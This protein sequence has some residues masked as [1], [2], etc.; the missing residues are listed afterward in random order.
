MNHVNFQVGQSASGGQKPTMLMGATLRPLDT[1]QNLGG[2]SNPNSNDV[3]PYGLISLQI[4]SLPAYNENQVL[5]DYN[6]D[7]PLELQDRIGPTFSFF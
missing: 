5:R 3:A 4:P 2:K 6:P 1:V 7:M